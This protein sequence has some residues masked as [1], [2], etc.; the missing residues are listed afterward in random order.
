MNRG[1][2]FGFGC[3]LIKRGYFLFWNEV[4]CYGLRFSVQL[5]LYSD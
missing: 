3:N 1:I 5:W 4:Y 2:L